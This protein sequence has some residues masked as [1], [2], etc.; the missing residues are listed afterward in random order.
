MTD[1][2]ATAGGRSGMALLRFGRKLVQYALV[3]AL[4]LTINFALPRLAPGDPLIYFAGQEINMLTAAQRERLKRELGL[5]RTVWQQYADYIGGAVTLKLGSSTKFGKPVLE[6]LRERMPWTALLVAPA[7]ALS[8][9]IGLLIGAYAAWHRG[10]RRDVALLTSMLALES[11]P[12]FWMGMLLVAVF[13]VQLGWLPSYGAAPLVR[14]SDAAYVREIIRHLI[15]PVT[16]IGLATT[17]AHFLLTRS[18]MLDTLGQDYMLMAEAKGVGRRGLIYRH[19]L[20]NALLPV[21]THMTMSVG[22]LVGGA[23]VVETVF[24]YPGIGRL[25]YESVTAR[26]FP[27][28]QGVFLLITVAV[29]AANLLAD[30]TYPLIDPRARLR[31]HVEGMR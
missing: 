23:V 13:S 18:S 17:G 16:T 24:S 20:R 7:L 28:M 9:C 29:I 26:D 14:T 25:L 22:A 8:A 1:Q 12:A 21:Y 3:L 2:P 4:A 15:L 19:A 11:L 5:D 31:R 10:K 30:L 27:M 6:V